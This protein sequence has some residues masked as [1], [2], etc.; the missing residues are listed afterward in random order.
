MEIYYCDECGQR[1]SQEEID[2]GKFAVGEDGARYCEGCR[3]KAEGK[4]S[5]EKRAPSSKARRATAGL[6]RDGSMRGPEKAHPSGRRSVRI[7]ALAA[8]A[9]ALLA[10]PIGYFLALKPERS[11]PSASVS[12]ATPTGGVRFALADAGARARF[13]DAFARKLS[14]E[15]TLVEEDAEGGIRLFIDARKSAGGSIWFG[16]KSLRWAERSELTLEFE[17]RDTSKA[18][19]L[20][21]ILAAPE[22]DRDVG[23]R[24]RRAYL[25]QSIRGDILAGL[26][27]D[28]S[29]VGYASG[30]K[31]ARASVKHDPGKKRSRIRLAKQGTEFT[32]E[33]DDVVRVAHDYGPSEASAF[34]ALPLIFIFGGHWTRKFDITIREITFGPPASAQ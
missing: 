23:R 31:E 32:F 28:R 12:E 26:T 14:S 17:R 29:S 16:A 2:R 9:G 7:V 21:I 20:E 22:K 11:G 1:I 30:I 3:P 4:R 15:T 33:V 24:R 5:R 13:R 6:S 19:F 34:E 25:Y 8:V 18:G 10:V 27:K